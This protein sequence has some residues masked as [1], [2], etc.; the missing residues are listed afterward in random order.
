V[1]IVTTWAATVKPGSSPRRNSPYRT[2][3]LAATA[4]HVLRF[5]FT[6]D[7]REL[8]GRA[9]PEVDNL[10]SLGMDVRAA[11]QGF[12]GIEPGLAGI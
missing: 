9:I 11:S 6:T 10:V 5:T 8:D 7:P 1:V 2:R 12:D 4:V 3:P